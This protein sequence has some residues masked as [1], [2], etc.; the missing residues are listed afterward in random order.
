[1]SKQPRQWEKIQKTGYCAATA[2]QRTALWQAWKRAATGSA[3]CVTRGY[4]NLS[5]PG[6]AL[7]L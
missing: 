5:P 1:M 3:G 6:N 7:K 4:S 2:V